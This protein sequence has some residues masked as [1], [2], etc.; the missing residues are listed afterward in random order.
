MNKLSGVTLALVLV[1]LLVVSHDVVHA[2]SFT[3]TNTSDSGPG[4]LRQAILDANTSP[5]TDTIDF[6]IPGAGP[7]T[8][9][10]TSVLPPII[11]SVVIDGDSIPDITIDGASSINVGFRVY[12]SDVTITGLSILNFSGSGIAIFTDDAQGRQLIERVLLQGNTISAG[13]SGID[14]YNWGQ[15]CTIRDID[16]KQNTL[17]NNGFCGISISAAFEPSTAESPGLRSAH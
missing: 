4:S 7:H 14:V 13:W 11:D 10:P 2:A 9:Q 8:I 15:D 5:G 16:I 1:L 12:A 6:N 3:V 17:V